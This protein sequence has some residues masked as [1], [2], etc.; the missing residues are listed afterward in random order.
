MLP[1]ILIVKKLFLRLQLLECLMCFHPQSHCVIIFTLMIW[2]IILSWL[3][4]LKISFL[5]TQWYF[6]HGNFKNYRSH[7][8]HLN[9]KPKRHKESTLVHNLTYVLTLVTTYFVLKTF[10]PS[11]LFCRSMHP[12][13]T[14]HAHL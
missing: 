2:L 14:T 12:N 4:L 7:M 3:L 5:C 8:F 11:Q 6:N 10:I 9:F 1:K 13:N